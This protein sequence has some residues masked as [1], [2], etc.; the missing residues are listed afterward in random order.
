MSALA[1]RVEGGVLTATIDRP[2]A[3][4]AIDGEVAHGL[5]EVMDRLDRDDTLR[6]GVITG[7]GGT[8]S[9]GM[10]L[11]AFLRGEE[12][13][14]GDRGFA[15]MC[16]RPTVKPLL[17]AVEGWALA[18]GCEIALTCDVIVAAEDARFGLPEARRGLIAAAGG[19][20]RLPRRVPPG[21]AKLMALT[22]EPVDGTEA[23]R[24]GLAD[25][26]VA[27]GQALAR[28]QEL[29]RTIA[30]NAPMAVAAS[31]RLVDTALDRAVLDAFTDQRELADE[32]AVSAD[33]REGAQ[34]F[35]DKR[36]PVWTGR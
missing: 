17:A 29:A 36:D 2:Q 8:F 7:A 31:K 20:L 10:D 22:G 15:G 1:V 6:V 16:T 24:L 18:G 21:A 9:A 3:R 4:N 26:L 13:H 23:H 5:A 28:A 25:V 27:S 34:A 12:V 19:L 32:I 14:V 35:V 30:S 11:K 33:A